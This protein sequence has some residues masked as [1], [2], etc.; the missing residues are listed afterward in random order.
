MIGLRGI[1]DGNETLSKLSDWTQYL[2][3]VDQNLAHA[4]DLLENQ[5]A[6]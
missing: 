3:V 5:L 6:S 4:V 2:H 1:S